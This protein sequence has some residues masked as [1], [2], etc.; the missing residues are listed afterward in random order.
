M[1]ESLPFSCAVVSG[2]H[3]YNGIIVL[4]LSSEKGERRGGGERGGGGWP[5]EKKEKGREGERQTAYEE[6]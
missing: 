3:G 5:G 6:R 2:S 4:F 1:A